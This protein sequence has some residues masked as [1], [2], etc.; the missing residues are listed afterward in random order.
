MG[1]KKHFTGKG[2]FRNK[3]YIV[4]EENDRN[5]IL[6][7]KDRNT[8]L[9]AYQVVNKTSLDKYPERPSELEGLNVYR[10]NDYKEAYKE[11]NKRNV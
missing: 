2:S 11:Y 5:Y 10:T 3:H 1:F 8:K 9:C 7:V 4:I 6:S